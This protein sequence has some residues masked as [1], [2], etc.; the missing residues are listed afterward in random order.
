[1]TPNTTSDT[2]G[3]AFLKALEAEITA[4]EAQ[5]A[6]KRALRD[7]VAAIYLNDAAAPAA[8]PAARAGRAWANGR[9]FNDAAARALDAID[10]GKTKIAEIEKA[11]GL[12]RA[13]VKEA[14][15]TLITNGYVVRKGAGPGTT[16]EPKGKR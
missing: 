7:Q 2:A 14:I 3:H 13:A 1:M 9:P 6:Q 8:A 16:Y 15:K 10:H 4:D 11:C 5:L 12:D